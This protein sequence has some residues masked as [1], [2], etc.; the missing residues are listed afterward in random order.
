MWRFVHDYWVVAAVTAGTCVVLSCT[1]GVVA[2]TVIAVREPG[3][4][5]KAVGGFRRMLTGK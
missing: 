3:T 5:G 1:T 2:F 4:L